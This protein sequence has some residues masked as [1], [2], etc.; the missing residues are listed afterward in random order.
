M[1]NKKEICECGH[2]TKD[3]SYNPKTLDS[4]LECDFCNCEKFTPKIEKTGCGKEFELGSIICKCGD[5]Y[6]FLYEEDW[7]IKLCPSCQEKFKENNI[8]LQAEVES[9]TS[10]NKKGA[11]NVGGFS[12]P[13]EEIKKKTYTDKEDEKWKTCN[14]EYYGSELV[15]NLTKEFANEYEPYYHQDN[16][17]LGMQKLLSL[18]EQEN[19]QNILRDVYDTVKAKD[20]EKQ[21]LLSSLQEKIEEEINNLKRINEDAPYDKDMHYNLTIQINTLENIKRILFQVKEEKQEEKK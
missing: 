6:K 4:N 20:I 19:I 2:H 3:H 21:E 8:H 1:K 7:N 16:F 11:N 12:T 10:G 17:I 9:R 14:Q 13:N 15:F 5:K 18:K